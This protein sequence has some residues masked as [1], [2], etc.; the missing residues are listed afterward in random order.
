MF[1][2]DEP[3]GLK[4]ELVRS[5]W[6]RFAK[7]RKQKLSKFAKFRKTITFKG[8][9]LGNCLGG[10]LLLHLERSQVDWKGFDSHCSHAVINIPNI[11]RFNLIFLSD[12]FI[13]IDYLQHSLQ[14]H[15]N[16][17]LS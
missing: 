5:T 14:I 15:R 11:I 10:V 17:I 2:V 4:T 13:A 8:D 7:F 16:S 9:H 12:T 1:Q 3:G 6:G